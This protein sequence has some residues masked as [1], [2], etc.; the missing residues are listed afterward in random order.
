MFKFAAFLRIDNVTINPFIPNDIYAYLRDVLVVMTQEMFEAIDGFNSLNNLGATIS[1]LIIIGEPTQIDE[2][3]VYVK[4]IKECIKYLSA[5]YPNQDWWFVGDN[6]TANEMI[7]KGL[8]MDVYI[9]KS[10]ARPD[11]MEYETVELHSVI[12]DELFD[13]SLLDDPTMGFNL[14]SNT[15]I[16]LYLIKKD[17]TIN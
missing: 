8:I 3:C 5:N 10:Y 4:D 12:Q 7:R 16:L 17:T 13:R 1:K 9:T 6:A 11:T 14:I 2:R 15:I